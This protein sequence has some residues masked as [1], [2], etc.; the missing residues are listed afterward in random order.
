[1][2]CEIT[3]RPPGYYAEP[4]ASPPPHVSGRGFT[5]TSCQSRDRV[6]LF[7]GFSSMRAW[8]TQP[9]PGYNSL[10]IGKPRD[11]G[12]DAQYS[13]SLYRDPD[14]SFSFVLASSSTPATSSYNPRVPFTTNPNHVRIHPSRPVGGFFCHGGGYCEAPR[15]EVSDPRDSSSAPSSRAGCTYPLIRR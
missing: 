6:P 15:G 7:T 12:G 14:S 11:P 2:V 13:G 8:V 4:V 1:M 5:G 3:S 10:E 9:S